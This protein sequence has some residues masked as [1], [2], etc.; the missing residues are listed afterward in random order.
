[1][2]PIQTADLERMVSLACRILQVDAVAISFLDSEKQHFKAMRGIDDC[3]G[4]DRS[5]PLSQSTCARVVARKKA[6]S[7]MDISHHSELSS[8]STVRKLGIRA[9]VGVP[10]ATADGQAVG[11][12]SAMCSEPRE[13]TEDDKFTLRD[14][15]RVIEADLVRRS[16]V[17]NRDLILKEMSH[18][19][20]NLCAVINGMIRLD[21][22][23]AETGEELA[24][25]LS[26]RVQ[27]LSAAH[28]LII[29]VASAGASS[30]ATTGLEQVVERLLRPFALD[31]HITWA[32]PDAALSEKTA[33]YIAL[34]LHEI[35][36]N[37]MKYSALSVHTGRVTVSW[38]LDDNQLTIRWKERGHNWP[39]PHKAG[40]GFGS[41]LLK[42]SIEEALRGTLTITQTP[43]AFNLKVDIPK[44]SMML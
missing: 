19:I 21:R 38:E 41:R 16:T 10:I 30:L 12:F 36:T 28:E 1:M 8:L 33:V 29:P 34:A 14:L 5:L 42:I 13:W 32:G 23:H 44:A 24:T 25:R 31:D 7:V 26:G 4:P 27:A 20:K 17:S 22:V 6:L 39:K 37:A 18:R 35:S 3:L 2:P 9:Y 43:S 15:A 11:C 40:K